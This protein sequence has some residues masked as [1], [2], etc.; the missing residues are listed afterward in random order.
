MLSSLVTN[1]L[2]MLIKDV[3]KDDIKWF[4]DRKDVRPFAGFVYSVI[5]L[6]TNCLKIVCSNACKSEPK[7]E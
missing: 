1:K 2:S 5:V 4:M 6:D 7:T 3:S